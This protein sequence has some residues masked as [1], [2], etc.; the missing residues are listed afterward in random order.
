MKA[1]KLLTIAASIQYGLS[2]HA[3]AD[4]N[5]EIQYDNIED[6]LAALALADKEKEQIHHQFFEL[7]WDISHYNTDLAKLYIEQDTTLTTD[8]RLSQIAPAIQAQ[9]AK[10][11]DLEK[12]YADLYSQAQQ[13][14]P[15]IISDK[16][17]SEYRTLEETQQNLADAKN[18]AQK[19]KEVF[20]KYVL[21]GTET[22]GPTWNDVA[23]NSLIVVRKSKTLMSDLKK[24]L[25]TDKTLNDHD[26]KALTTKTSYLATGITTFL[27]HRIKTIQELNAKNIAD[28]QCDQSLIDQL[29]AE[30]TN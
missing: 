14:A 13:R 12:R 7:K 24:R 22:D 25:E 26:R 23:S 29:I 21:N 20:I 4:K 1:I 6:K 3:M 10:L 28:R 11:P 2:I 17:T 30:Q 16:H 5:G 19:K 8:V 18:D 9:K 15:S 27:T